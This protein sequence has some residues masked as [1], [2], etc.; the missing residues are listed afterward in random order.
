MSSQINQAE[1]VLRDSKS[2]S[3]SLYGEYLLKTQKMVDNDADVRLCQTELGAILHQ[4]QLLR[5]EER[6]LNE[7]CVSGLKIQ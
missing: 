3:E 1:K 7:Q 2:V 5:E 4:E 6:K